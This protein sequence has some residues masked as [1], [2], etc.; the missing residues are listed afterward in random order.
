MNKNIQKLPLEIEKKYVNE[1]KSS[2]G[3]IVT[4]YVTAM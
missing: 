4:L 2:L 3:F 1:R